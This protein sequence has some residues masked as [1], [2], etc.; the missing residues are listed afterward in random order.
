LPP[1]YVEARTSAGVGRVL[2][3]SFS[4]VELELG[5]EDEQ[6]AIVTT[7]IADLPNSTRSLIE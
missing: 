4:L 5:G 7:T 3:L 2:T 6:A 1:R